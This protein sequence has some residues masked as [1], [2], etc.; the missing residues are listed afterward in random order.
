MNRKGL[1]HDGQ[2]DGSSLEVKII[3]KPRFLG[4]HQSK[5]APAA[6]VTTK[7]LM[8]FCFLLR[9][10][11]AKRGG[12]GDT[13]RELNSAPPKRKMPAYRE[14]LQLER[15]YDLHRHYE[16]LGHGFGL[17]MNDLSEDLQIELAIENS[18]LM[19]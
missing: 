8:C 19:A 3:R 4:C 5:I 18:L 17:P 2:D 14:D 13:Y 11:R 10:A 15:H 9:A 6:G 12:R 1:L 7:N 16:G